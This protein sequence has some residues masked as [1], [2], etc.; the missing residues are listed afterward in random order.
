MLLGS[1]VAGCLKTPDRYAASTLDVNVNPPA[2]FELDGKPFCFA[3]ANNYYLHFLARPM[4]DD[5]L[6]SARALNFSVMRMWAFV[7]IGSLD[8]SVQSIDPY[9]DPDGK[10]AGV[11]YQYWDSKQKQV[12]INEGDNG[13]K[14]L[15]YALAKAAQENVKIIMV[16]TNNWNDFGGMAQY[17]RWFGRTKHYEFYTAPEVK[18]AYKNWVAHL[19][20]R[21]NT[22][23][24]RVYRDDPTIFSWELGNE[25]RC[26]GTGPGAP[27]WTTDT[28]PTWVAEMSAYIKSIAPNHMVSVGDEGFLDGGGEHWAYK[29]NDGVDHEKITAVPTVDFGT[30][31]MY[32][33]DWGATLE[34]G[35]RWVIDHL[36]VARRLNKPTILEEYGIKVSRANDNQ[37]PIIKGLEERLHH[38]KRW[39]DAVFQRGGNG[40][41]AWILSGREGDGWYKDYDHYTLYRGDETA[42][43]LSDYARR[44][45]IESAACRAATPGSGTPSQFVRVRRSGQAPEPVAQALGWISPG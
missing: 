20:N 11:Y 31:H 25:P 22:V 39:N 24:G 28:I 1:G 19:V 43:L 13:L 23:N 5:V 18:Q 10:K 29:A 12:V 32:P 42:N 6:E 16:L 37:G 36:R 40:A 7:D 9:S 35:R 38:Y 26:K 27:G 2:N 8:G 45:P 34:W 41:M 15:D 21:T 4:V 30:F 33:E 44:F 14:R 3:G 17:L